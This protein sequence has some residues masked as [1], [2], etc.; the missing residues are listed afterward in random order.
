MEH[1][2]GDGDYLFLALCALVFV[3]AMIGIWYER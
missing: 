3:C 1:E 2:L